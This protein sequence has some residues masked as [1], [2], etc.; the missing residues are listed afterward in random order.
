V[1]EVRT[2]AASDGIVVI[3]V[4]GEV[5]LTVSDRLERVLVDAARATATG[6]L[7][8]D[9]QLLRFLDSSGV[10]A[11]LRGYQAARAAGRSLTVRNAR[12]MVARVLTITGVGEALG[13]PVPSS[14]D[15]QENS[16]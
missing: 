16:V 11:L 13:L 10:Q 5:D 7:V 2:E 8:V 3:L 12:G 15:G 4:A 1:F 6:P 14:G 9:L